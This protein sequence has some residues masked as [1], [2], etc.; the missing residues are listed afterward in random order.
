MTC[1]TVQQGDEA[2]HRRL[3]WRVGFWVA[4]CAV[5]AYLP[6]IGCDFV[7]LDDHRNYRYNEA[8]QYSPAVALFWAWTTLWIG[9]YQPLA[10]MLILMEH[11]IWAIH[12]GGYHAVSLALHGAVAVAL[13]VVTRKIL[14][15]A[16]PEAS[17]E[18]PDSLVIA[19]GLATAIFCVHPL[20]TEAV[21][22]LSAQPYLPSVL[23]MIAGVGAYLESQQ[24]Q[25]SPRS[26]RLWLG[27]SF[28]L[29]AAAMLFKAV[30]VTFPLILL[31]LD[32][33]PLQRLELDAGD[34]RTGRQQLRLRALRAAKLA[35]E[36]LPLLLL[37]LVLMT[38]AQRAKCFDRFDS[39][40][41]LAASWSAR[42]ADAARGVWFYPLKTLVPIELT[43]VYP[44]ED[45]T[46]VHLANPV[47]ALCAAGVVT[48]TVL[49]W[50]MRRAWPG[51]ASA[52]TLYLIILAPNSGLVRFSP[53][54]AADRYSYAAS[55]PW[56]PL[57]AGAFIPLLNCRRSLRLSVFSVASCMILGLSFLSWYQTATWRHSVALWTH[58]IE[59]GADRSLEAHGNLA[60]ALSSGGLDPE[61]F[62]HYQSAVRVAPRSAKARIH[63][64][65][66][67]SRR[68]N[69]DAAIAQMR[70]AVQV[71]P[72]DARLH[73]HL[74]SFL[75]KAGR[76]E[77]AEPEL[78]QAIT[79]NPAHFEAHRDLGVLLALHGKPAEARTHL[80]IAI[81][82][83]PDDQVAR[84]NFTQFL[85][86]QMRLKKRGHRAAR[87]SQEQAFFSRGRF[88]VHASYISSRGETNQPG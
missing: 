48:M 3:A 45:A 52:W 43:I 41:P 17:R 74:A 9:V 75:M 8:L 10:W 11:A 12:P 87:Q 78:R 72:E 86:E 28:V 84:T 79:L 60:I 85:I 73:Y 67:L 18:R 13:F 55:L 16:L 62:E 27:A 29:G 59:T 40:E 81:R 35:I 50:R 82:L 46:F 38:I 49:A 71:I 51:L 69:L 22:W 68:G 63:L 25:R 4:V 30:A 32:V 44:R 58:A 88:P 31:V 70:T 61:A 47:F 53:Q 14:Q 34:G 7:N 24:P 20:R 57:L 77:D 83:R 66:A 6:A 36:K 1:L 54:F 80:M 2:L 76:W 33:Y 19:A 39:G 42:L 21:V 5:L 26:A 65:E 56:V 15:R 23:C 64:A 37:S